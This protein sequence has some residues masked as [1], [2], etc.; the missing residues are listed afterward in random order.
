MITCKLDYGGCSASKCDEC[1]NVEYFQWIYKHVKYMHVCT[2]HFLVERRNGAI[3]MR[4][5]FI[6]VTASCRMD[7]QHLLSVWFQ[8][9]CLLSI[10]DVRPT[11]CLFAQ[12][13]SQSPGGNFVVMASNPPLKG[14]RFLKRPNFQ[15]DVL[16]H[17]LLFTPGVHTSIMLN[18]FAHLVP[19]WIA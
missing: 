1:P 14:G 9:R 5:R 2:I 17:S 8:N 4:K 11:W 18:V 6:N 7:A 12:D 3:K 15:N 10:N 16:T 13:L 19:I